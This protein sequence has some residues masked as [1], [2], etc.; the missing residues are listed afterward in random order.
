MDVTHIQRMVAGLVTYDAE[1]EIYAD[2]D[3]D[4]A[5]TIMDATELQRWIA[6]KL[7]DSKIGESYSS[8]ITCHDFYSDYMSGSAVARAPVAFTCI[9]D[10]DSPMQSYELYVDGELVAKRIDSNRL[11][12]AFP[13]AGVYDVKM[14]ANAFYDSREKRIRDFVVVDSEENPELRFKTVYTTGKYKGD[15]VYDLDGITAYAEA[16]G[17]TAPYEY[18]FLFGYPTDLN[19]SNSDL[20]YDFQEYSSDNS[21]DLPVIEA[22]YD[23]RYTVCKLKVRIKDANGDIVEYVDDIVYQ[24]P[25]IG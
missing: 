9:V 6:N 21:Y 3:L 24:H 2:V 17:G 12:Y 8:F 18:K 23:A 1:D 22:D 11:L 10:A 14:V 16:M 20:I 25:K 5:V 19:D 7:E 4:R 15:Y 13:E